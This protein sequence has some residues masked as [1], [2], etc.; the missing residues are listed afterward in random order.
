MEPDQGLHST[1]D[2]EVKKIRRPLPALAAPFRLSSAN[3]TC[4]YLGVL[5]IAIA[6]VGLVA[7]GIFSAH[8]NM[9]HNILFLVTGAGSLILGLIKPDYIATKICYALGAFYLLL[10]IAG[11]AF[12]VRALSLTRPTVSGLPAESAFLWRLIPGRFELGTVDHSIHLAVGILFFIGAYLT[13]RK[14]RADNKV[15]WH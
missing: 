4:W 3:Q 1:K 7:P 2:F 10:G 13:I 5:L 9:A 14:P 12:G 11:F 8:L 6:L 15:T